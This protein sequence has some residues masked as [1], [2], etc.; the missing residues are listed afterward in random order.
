MVVSKVENP[1]DFPSMS[2][3]QSKDGDGI[4]S[5]SW[6]NNYI[7]TIGPEWIRTP[8]MSN[9]MGRNNSTRRGEERRLIAMFLERVDSINLWYASLYMQAAHYS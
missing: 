2:W 4:A 3:S 7:L 8:Q 1:W 5:Y 9:Q 6:S